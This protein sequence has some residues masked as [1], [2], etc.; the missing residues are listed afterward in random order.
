M[1]LKGKST[2]ITVVL[3]ISKKHPTLTK[4]KTSQL[5]RNEAKGWISK[6]VLQEHKARQTVPNTNISSPLIRTRTCAYQGV[7]NVRFSGNWACFVFLKYSFWD[8]PFCLITD[9]LLHVIF[10]NFDILRV[11][12]HCSTAISDYVHLLLVVVLYLTPQLWLAV[13]WHPHQ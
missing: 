6:R 1:W 13:V 2:L 3:E 12:A 5:V 9:E 11:L 10:R 8:S 7:R 4:G